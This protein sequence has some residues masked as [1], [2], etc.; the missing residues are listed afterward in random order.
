MPSELR[1]FFFKP[2]P[3]WEILPPAVW[4]ALNAVSI[5]QS[6]AKK[7]IIYSEGSHPRGLYIIRKGRL[8]VFIIDKNGSELI[9]YFLGK[10]EFFGY[11]SIVCDENSPVYVETIEDCMV[12]CIPRRYFEHHLRESPEMNAAFFYY[13]GHEFRLFVN[14]M[15]VFAQKPVSERVALALLVLDEKFREL[16]HATG[17]LNFTRENL[18]AY[19]GTAPESL[20]RQLKVLKESGAITVKGRKIILEKP[21]VLWEKAG[22]SPG[23]DSGFQGIL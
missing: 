5:S 11:R 3:F 4:D 17:V 15:S 8:K 20:I 18:A 19:I 23:I 12:D 22:L 14:K 10:D 7:T 13:L 2:Q 1:N 16:P 9:I 6:Y 21:A